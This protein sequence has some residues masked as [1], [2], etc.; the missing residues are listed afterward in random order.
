MADQKKKPLISCY[1]L[2]ECFSNSLHML[3]PY[4]FLCILIFILFMV[5][6]TAALEE[7]SYV[8]FPRQEDA[9]KASNFSV[10]PDG[11]VLLALEATGSNGFPDSFDLRLLPFVGENGDRVTVKIRF[12]EIPSS[13]SDTLQKDIKIKQPILPIILEV[14]TLKTAENY[15]GRMI[16]SVQGNIKKGWPI[17]I[18]RA[19]IPKP[20]VLIIDQQAISL[21][22]QKYK[23]PFWAKKHDAE[24]TVHLQEKNNE[25]PIEQIY[26]QLMEVKGIEGKFNVKEKLDFEIRGE[27]VK[28]FW[29]WPPQEKNDGRLRKFNQGERLP[30]RCKIRGL[31]AGEYSVKLGFR[32]GN[33]K[34][35]DA[36]VLT[37]SLKVKHSVWGPLGLLLF[38][39]AFS[40]LATKWLKIRRQ[41][42]TF[43]RQIFEMRPPWLSTARSILPV[44]W[45]RA[46]LKQAEDR[47]KKWVLSATD[48][49]KMR[50]DQV[51]KL[52]KPLERISK[53]LLEMKRLDVD[54]M[55]VLRAEKELR[56]VT[57]PMG[58]GPI[59]EKMSERISTEITELELW[60]KSKEELTER[61][62][63]SLKSDIIHLLEKTFLEEFPDVYRNHI[64]QLKNDLED[65]L[66]PD[67]VPK[68]LK[69]AV[70]CEK[71]YS[72][73]KILWERR[74]LE[75]DFEKLISLHKENKS[76]ESLFEAADDV[77]WVRLKNAAENNA[78]HLIP[79]KKASPETFEAYQ[80]IIFNVELDDPSLGDNYLFKHKL[81]YVWVFQLEPHQSWLSKIIK[82]QKE[83]LPLMPS[84]NE[85]RVVQY[86]PGPGKLTAS[87]EAKYKGDNFS[88][89][90]VKE[91]KI[92]KSR[93]FRWQ[94]AFE[95]T[96]IW[97][98]A[99]ASVIG[100]LTGLSSLYLNNPTFGSAK[101]Y[102]G[103][104]FW[105]VG[106]DQAKNFIQILQSYSAQ[107][108]GS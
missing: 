55:V 107:P 24:F 90:M 11:R 42:L 52:F 3:K 35:D 2:V 61:Y 5:N 30:I 18:K 31:E 59:D 8:L 89:L 23:F 34:D 44:V 32:A 103:L 58:A 104:F 37:L 27:K 29:S 15:S 100:L 87:V 86:A 19:S 26:I 10:P 70:E 1:F 14:P 93:D 105:G 57:D 88:I 36:Q 13:K 97:A 20:S 94:R 38:A 69:T 28:D 108:E 40:Y 85:P 7:E 78:I 92:G 4:V 76:V 33:S 95:S 46:M 54:P 91:L 53:F 99:I 62:W 81:S 25:W 101:D 49:I 60:L 84:T 21:S 77:V 9:A 71:K 98:L 50:I 6:F 72:R 80:P 51:T 106:A 47:G 45:I 66:E 102:L 48:I 83:S 39:I 16:M 17:V 82:G 68:E 41:Q 12:P 43:R 67:R 75:D 73:L 65:T 22:V 96:E 74:F 63:N 64:E 56:R 79:P